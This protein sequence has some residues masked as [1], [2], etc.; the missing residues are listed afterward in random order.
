MSH[1]VIKLSVVVDTDEL[2]KWA[3]KHADAH[4]HGVAT[5]LY[6]A[7][8]R[9]DSQIL[10]VDRVRALHGEC[11]AR[12]GLCHECGAQLPCATLRALDGE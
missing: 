1:K 4:N 11:T 10:G 6:N 9:L 3:D 7:A 5:V 8:E 12:C 2:R